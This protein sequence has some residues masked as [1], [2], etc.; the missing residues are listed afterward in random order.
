M[1]R[2]V[3]RRLLAAIPLVL[4][5]LTIVFLLVQMAP[6]D[7]FS[8]EPGAGVSRGSAEHLRQAFGADRPM[9]QRYFAWLGGFLTGDLGVSFSYRRPVAGLLREAV[10]N[11]LVLTG[12]AILLQF[13]LGALTGVA[14]AASRSRWVDRAFLFGTSLVYSLP[15]YWLGLVMVWLF[16][17]RLGWLPVSQMHSPDVASMGAWRALLDSTV[18]LVLP[19]LSLTLPAGAGIAIYVRDEVR[20]VIARN[21]IRMARA[22][23]VTETGIYFRHALRGAA[24]PLVNLLGLALPGLVGGSLVLEVLFSW[25]GMGRLAHQAV[26]SRDEPLILGCAW[27]GT[28]LVVAGSLAADLLSAWLSPRLREPS[29]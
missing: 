20:A 6:G 3:G 4:G 11:S 17:V 29:P 25:P 12:T 27:V 23:G 1:V 8:L 7:P 10:A 22:R 15:S 5:V 24:L 28:L 14:A 16:S 9:L 13:L 26:L 19:C 18:H 2:Y 21:P